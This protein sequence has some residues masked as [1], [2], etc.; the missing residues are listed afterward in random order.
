[1][2]YAAENNDAS[3]P[4]DYKVDGFTLGNWVSRQRRYW[5]RLSEEQQNRL[6]QI[7]SWSLLPAKWNR[8][9]RLLEAYAAE[10]G[11]A[12]V[13]GTLVIDG[14]TLGRWA[15]KQRQYWTR[16]TDEQ[17]AR[18]EV[19][20][21]WIILDVGDREKPVGLRG[22]GWEE[23]F[24]H[25]LDYV[26]DHGTIRKLHRR[27]VCNGYPLGDWITGQMSRWET[28]GDER[29]KRLSAIPG[30]TLDKRADRWEEGF[31]LLQEYVQL[32]GTSRVP[33][34]VI[35]KDFKLAT[36][37]ATQRAKWDNMP[38]ERQQRL[39]ALPDW[40]NNTKQALWDEGYAYLLRYLEANGDADVPVALVFEGFKLGPWVAGQRG[41]YW[42]GEIKPDREAK[43]KVLHGWLWRA[44][45]GF[46][47]RRR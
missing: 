6:N 28:L 8:A 22:V 29:Q 27:A 44:P 4:Y 35:Y 23:A 3:P 16:L 19:L 21:G 38:Q 9:C 47:A 31:S 14:D 24:Q 46:A 41:L 10:H 33:R 17:R 45:R 26:A 5:E 12:A 2:Q 42:K 13:T 34:G 15:S 39:L 36:W 11:T 37:V 18:L 32:H 1:M 40:T 25:L 7:D 30:W 43:L 20:P